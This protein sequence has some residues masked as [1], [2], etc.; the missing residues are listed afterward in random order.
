MTDEQS[1]TPAAAAGSDQPP[2]R[3]LGRRGLLVIVFGLLLIVAPVLLVGPYVHFLWTKRSPT[4]VAVYAGFS[5]RQ[6]PEFFEL[7]TDPD[8]EATSPVFVQ[9]PD[10]K[11]FALDE[12]PE[13]AAA[14]LLPQGPPRDPPTGAN[15]YTDAKSYLNYRDGRLVF[16]VLHAKSKLFGVG[17]SKSGPF[18]RLPLSRDQLIAAFGEP[19]RWQQ[20]AQAPADDGGGPGP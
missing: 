2:S 5:L 11:A 10:G 12:L 7:V 15:E 6:D 17:R 1:D 4:P 18:A 3:R 9:L 20:T 16:A 8:A 14:R 13:D 19:L